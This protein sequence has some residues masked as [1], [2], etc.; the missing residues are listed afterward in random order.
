MISLTEF[1]IEMLSKV[2]ALPGKVGMEELTDNGK[3]LEI[4]GA[5][6]R[7]TDLGKETYEPYLRL[8]S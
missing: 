6:Y 1:Q 2:N 4:P 5:G 3:N 7:L 8:F